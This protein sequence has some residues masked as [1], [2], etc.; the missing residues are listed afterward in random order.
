MMR[1]RDD[2]RKLSSY[3]GVCSDR[4]IFRALLVLF[5]ADAVFVFNAKAPRWL[6][7]RRRTDWLAA[8]LLVPRSFFIARRVPGCRNRFIGSVA[9]GHANL[10]GLFR[11]R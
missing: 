6:D 5:R 2:E 1:S 4:P 3:C 8:G 11:L 9:R 10:W 7:A